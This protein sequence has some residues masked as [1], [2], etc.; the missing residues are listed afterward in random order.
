MIC[1]LHFGVWITFFFYFMMFFTRFYSIWVVLLVCFLFVQ[2]GLVII[3]LS[4][5]EYAIGFRVFCG[6]AFLC[7][8]NCEFY[9]WIVTFYSTKVRL[10]FGKYYNDCLLRT[11]LHIEFVLLNYLLYEGKYLLNCETNWI[12]K[13]AE[14]LK[15]L[16]QWNLLNCWIREFWSIV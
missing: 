4:D 3:F 8:L 5:F 10:L 11:K 16:S 1:L 13:L 9:E 12:V 15:L 6:F 7:V 2:A 14:F